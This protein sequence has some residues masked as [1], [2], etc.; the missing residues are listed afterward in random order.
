MAETTT[1]SHR[2]APR[3]RRSDRH[4]S[5]VG[6]ARALLGQGRLR[7]DARRNRRHAGGVREDAAAARGLGALRG[8][9]ARDVGRTSPARSR[10]AAR[11]GR[12]RDRRDGPRR[13]SAPSPID[14]P[15]QP[16]EHG[17]DF[18]LDH[19]HFWLRSTAAARDLRRSA[20]RS[21]RRSTISST[22]AAS[23]ASTRRS[24]RRRSASAAGCSR[25][26]TST[27]GTRTSRRPASS[28]ARPPRRRSERSTPSA[29]PS[30]PRSRRRA[31]T[32]PSSG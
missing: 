32:S 28:T 8:A 6:H 7:C 1:S 4:R 25:R 14:Y 21:S 30:A 27:K 16:K 11:A 12:L 18:L 26:S 10:R 20:T 13:S 2:R 24:S 17:I 31:G 5:R 23:F 9:D 15:I 29:R 22:S 3:S 19:R